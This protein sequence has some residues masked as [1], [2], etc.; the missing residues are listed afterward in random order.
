MAASVTAAKRTAYRKA[1]QAGELDLIAVTTQAGGVGITLT[2]SDCAVFLQRPWSLVDAI[3]AEDRLHRIG[4][5]GHES[6]EIIDIVTE[7][8]VDMR[9]REKLRE[10]GQALSDLLQDP[11]IVNELLGGAD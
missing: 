2:A 9:V 3:Q 8:T 1:F 5:E 6:I 11:R 10:K 7:G 4:A